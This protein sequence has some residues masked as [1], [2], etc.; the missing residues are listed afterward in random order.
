MPML[1]IE[2]KQAEQETMSMVPVAGP[3]GQAMITSSV[4]DPPSEEMGVDIT[5]FL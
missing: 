1:A 3:S 4:S 2:M 5:A